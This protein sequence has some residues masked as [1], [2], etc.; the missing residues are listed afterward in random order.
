MR[1]EMTGKSVVLGVTGGIAAYK[2]CEVVSRLRKMG[3]DVH[4]VMTKSATEFV[5]PLTFETLSNHPVVT[6]TF[7][8]PATWEVEHIALAKR[9]DVFVIAPAT[10]NI[11]A[12][13]AHG[14]A[15]DMLSTTVLAT[16]APVLVA[17]A[18][19]S[20]MW[21]APVTQE[22]CAAL[23]GR[24]VHFIGPDAGFLAC[25]DTGAGRMSEPAA[26]V[27]AITALL[28]PV[29]DM[30]GLTV[31][32]TAGATRE[33][34]DPVRYMTNDS[35]GK[36]GFAVA[37]AALRRGAQVTVVAGSVTAALP[38]GCEVVRVESTQE[39]YE[40]VTSRAP[41]MDVVIQAAAPADYR[42][43]V[44]YPEKHKK[45]HDGQPFVVELLENPDIAAA[46]GAAKKPGQTLVGFAAET[47]NLLT[48]ARQKLVKKHLDLIVANDVSQPGAGF[49]VDTN[50][51]TLITAQ[52]MTECP[53]RTKKE[54]AGD[55]L[56]KVMALRSKA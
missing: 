45:A 21:T 32:V 14:I 1:C 34:L 4:V 10:A 6:D 23:K 11:L 29:Q 42:F 18:M 50:I 52:E 27:E 28:C 24:G 12:K 47:E 25:G 39:L 22:N 9:A 49:N 13:M 48:N 33:R 46:V 51:A 20:G 36:M 40:A 3:A 19:N 7:A 55:I 54:L 53:L 5:Q 38:T 16:K 26:I 35:S 43:A 15:D 17:P 44:T 2:A 56:D 37:E 41:D 31:L 30:A 8:R